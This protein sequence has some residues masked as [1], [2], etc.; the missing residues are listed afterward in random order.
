MMPVNSPRSFLAEN[1][2]EQRVLPAHGD[3]RTERLEKELWLLCEFRTERIVAL[4]R[5][6]LLG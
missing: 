4:V 1:P 3:S 2:G 5:C 6:C